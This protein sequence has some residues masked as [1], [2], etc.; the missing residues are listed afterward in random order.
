MLIYQAGFYGIPRSIAVRRAEY[1][2]KRLDLWT[3][4]DKTIASLSGGLKRRLMIARALINEPRLLILD[5]P[6]AG[7]D[8]ELRHSI[9]EFLKELNSKGTTIILTT[10]YLEEAEYLCNHLAIINHGII[11]ENSPITESL[12]RLTH[13]TFVLFLKNPI[14]DLP[15]TNF[16]L[17]LIDSQTIEADILHG[18]DLKQ[19]FAELS[20]HQIDIP[21]LRNKS[22][23]LEQLFLHLT[24]ETQ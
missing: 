7:V 4:R 23:R 16:N 24:K 9:W 15:R 14:I 11:I 20:Q 2:L 6:T 8:I 13:E 1:Y 21:S 17:R 3:K 18:Q 10:H 19:L 22:S 12:K 5:E